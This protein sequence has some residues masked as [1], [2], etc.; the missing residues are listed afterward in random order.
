MVIFSQVHPGHQ[1]DKSVHKVPSWEPRKGG[2]QTGFHLQRE[3][4][5]RERS[6]SFRGVG[7]RLGAGRFTYEN[8]TG[9]V[10]TAQAKGCVHGVD[11]GVGCKVSGDEVHH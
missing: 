4:T 2:R 10:G 1:E 6:R 11:R 9:W 8:H 5:G 7:L 3:S